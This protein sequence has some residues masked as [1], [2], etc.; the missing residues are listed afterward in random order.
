MKTNKWEKYGLSRLYL[1]YRGESWGRKALAT[2]YIDLLSEEKI[3]YEGSGS[4]L[5]RDM[6]RESW[7]AFLAYRDEMK[8]TSKAKKE[9]KKV[10]NFCYDCGATLTE[11]HFCPKCNS[12]N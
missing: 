7:E 2:A 12:Y 4:S 6:K 5:N 11:G 8:A 9:T 3:L 10:F 1:E